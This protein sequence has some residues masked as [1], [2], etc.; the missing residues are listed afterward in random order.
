MSIRQHLHG[1]ALV[2]AATLACVAAVPA[3]AGDISVS[4]GWARAM[5]PVTKTTAGYLVI[6]NQGK[7]DDVLLGAC[8]DDVDAAE[9]HEMVRDGDTLSMRRRET[10]AIPAGGKIVLAPGGMHLMLIDAKQPLKAGSRLHGKL[11]FR[12][13]GDVDVVLDVRAP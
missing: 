11:H 4:G 1:V 10:V 9:V 2:V 8:I 12:D 5:P 6:E 7:K 13:A 3:T